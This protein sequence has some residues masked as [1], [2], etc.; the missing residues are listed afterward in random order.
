MKISSSKVPIFVLPVIVLLGVTVAGCT[1]K[2]DLTTEKTALENQV[3]GTY[4][5]IDD[6]LILVSAVRGDA[7]ASDEEGADSGL[8]QS[9][10][11]ARQNQQFNQDDLDELKDAG[12]IGEARNGELQ[13]LS[14]ALTGLKNTARKN[15]ARKNTARKATGRNA[16]SHLVDRLVAEEN[17]DRRTIWLHLIATDA[18]LEAKDLPKIKRASAQVARDGAPPGH[19]IQSDD[20]SWSQVSKN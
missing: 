6:E 2:F 19:W 1:F 18:N 4:K 10:H 16:P 12:T 14:S 5:T 13:V 3:L 8:I 11:R 9:Y 20:G 7:P 15:T 17:R